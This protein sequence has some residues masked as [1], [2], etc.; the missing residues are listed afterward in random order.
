MEILAKLRTLM[1]E[2][3]ELCPI[4]QGDV[5]LEDATRYG[6]TLGGLYNVSGF[7]VSNIYRFYGGWLCKDRPCW[8]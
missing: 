6:G 1:P 7:A 3:F 5:I 2:P 4:P 8:Q